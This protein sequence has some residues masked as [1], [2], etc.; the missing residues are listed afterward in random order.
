MQNHCTRSSPLG[1]TSE[2]G[3][4]WC[5]SHQVYGKSRACEI[6]AYWSSSQIV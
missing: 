5:L 3:S 2:G 4:G 1:C 6:C